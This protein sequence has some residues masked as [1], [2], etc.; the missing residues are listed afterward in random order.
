MNQ[1]KCTLPL[2][3]LRTLYAT[4]HE[5]RSLPAAAED[6]A[7][8]IEEALGHRDLVNALQRIANIPASRPGTGAALAEARHIAIDALAKAG[9]A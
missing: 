2:E 7:G 6:F 9:A 3:A 4:T 5:G 1:P 8:M